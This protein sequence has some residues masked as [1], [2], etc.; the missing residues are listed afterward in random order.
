MLDLPRNGIS[1][2]IS[3]KS[4]SKL[5][6]K[7]DGYKLTDV[8]FLRIWL[9]LRIRMC[10]I[11]FKNYGV[12]MD[13]YEHISLIP[14][15]VPIGITK[16]RLIS[17]LWGWLGFEEIKKLHTKQAKAKELGASGEESLEK[18]PV[19]SPEKSQEK[20][21]MK[22]QEKASK[23]QEKP[24]KR[25]EKKE[26]EEKIYV[27]QVQ[28]RVVQRRRRRKTTLIW[29]LCVYV[30]IHIYWWCKSFIWNLLLVL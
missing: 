11:K 9:D 20:S 25:T 16:K 21:P 2:V 10:G 18:A 19:K 22:I 28:E 26:K 4:W 15:A 13:N 12:G 29:S 1:V 6:D 24:A 7:K 27:I 23:K 14:A 30:S 5:F 8:S 3:L 17:L